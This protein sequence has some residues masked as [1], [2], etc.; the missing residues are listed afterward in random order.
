MKAVVAFNISATKMMG[1]PEKYQHNMVPKPKE[2]WS[3][4]NTT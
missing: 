3:I 1:G 4:T 2:N